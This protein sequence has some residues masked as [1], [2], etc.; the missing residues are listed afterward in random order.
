[1]LRGHIMSM[2]EEKACGYFAKNFNCAQ[3]VIGAFCEEHGLDTK[4]A[5]RLANGFGGG[6]RYGEV[7][8]A[9]S[10]AIMAIGLKC[11]FYIEGDITQKGYCHSKTQEFIEKFRGGYGS[12]LCRDLLGVDI[13]V[14]GDHN[15][16]AAKEKHKSICPG[17]VGAAVRILEGMEIEVSGGGD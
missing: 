4:T 1:M 16:P 3:S 10:G 12:I 15:D 9:V 2:R 13:R 14:P 11:G 17:L 6:F 7:C 5:F 8:G